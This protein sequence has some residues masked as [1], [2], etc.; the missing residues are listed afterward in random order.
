MSDTGFSVPAESAM[1]FGDCHGV[2]PETGERMVFDSADGQWSTPPAFPSG[3]AGL[4]STLDDYHAF[5]QM[6]AAGGT[7][8][9]QQIL[10]R[11]SVEAMTVNHL[12]PAQLATSPPGGPEGG[13]G[14]GFGVGVQVDRIG[15]TRPIGSYGWDG[16]LGTTWANDPAND[17]IGILLTT[18]MWSSPTP[19]A[20]CQDFWTC[21]YAALDD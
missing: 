8:R 9:R 2:D 19:P 20:A 18:E 21:A 14:W 5:A 17:L 13:L 4:V 12:T 1:R 7:H 10:S 16:G 11:S 3:G 6:L 15:P